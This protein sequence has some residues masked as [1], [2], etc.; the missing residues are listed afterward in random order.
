MYFVAIRFVL[1]LTEKQRL[2]SLRYTKNRLF[3]NDIISSYVLL[4]SIWIIPIANVVNFIIIPIVLHYYTAFSLKEI[5]LISV[6]W[7]AFQPIYGLLLVK[8]WDFAEYSIRNLRRCAYFAFKPDL[9]DEMV[10][11]RKDILSHIKSNL[12]K[13]SRISKERLSSHSHKD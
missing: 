6:A 13:A 2:A 7:L 1:H 12:L 8:L 3:A 10:E 9:M 11:L 4:H 5:A